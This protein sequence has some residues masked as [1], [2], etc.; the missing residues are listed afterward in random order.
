MRFLIASDSFKDSLSAFDVGEAAR[1]GILSAMPVAHV[2]NA[3]MAD[4]ERGHSMHCWIPWMDK[5]V[6]LR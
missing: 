6:K 5:S 3:P 1:E 4:G 2:V